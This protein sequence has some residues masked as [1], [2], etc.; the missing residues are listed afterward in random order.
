MFA[1]MTCN[2]LFK[3]WTLWRNDNYFVDHVT[4]GEPNHD[5]ILK[6]ATTDGSMYGVNPR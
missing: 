4:L 3:P 2:I 6:D 5:V 1:I